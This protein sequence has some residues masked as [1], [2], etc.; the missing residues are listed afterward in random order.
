MPHVQHT[1]I[2]GQE[3]RS[4]GIKMLTIRYS[5]RACSAPSSRRPEGQHSGT[6]SQQVCSGSELVKGEFVG[7]PIGKNS[8][9][10][11][12]IPLS[13]GLRRWEVRFAHMMP[14]H[15]W[16]LLYCT[17]FTVHTVAIDPTHGHAEWR[18][19]R[20]THLPYEC[21]H[22]HRPGVMLEASA[23]SLPPLGSSWSFMALP[24]P[25][26]SCPLHLAF[27][28]VSNTDVLC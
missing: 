10:E 6:G 22:L 5:C 3:T 8:G 4:V 13:E 26:L 28:S 19:G 21:F 7:K 11:M 9:M 27:P 18:S 14:A 25:F 24:W 17:Y 23:S 2:R 12:G 1:H 16:C 15:T 20:E